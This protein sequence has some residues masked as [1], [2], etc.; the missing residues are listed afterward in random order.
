MTTSLIDLAVA[1]R[2]LAALTGEADPVVTWQTFDDDKVHKLDP[3]PMAGIQHGRLGD[4]D[5][6]LVEVNEVG[7]TLKDGR[8]H[9][10][11]VFIS[12]N[13]MNG[14]G[15]DKEDCVA[16]R[17]LFIDQDG[18]DPLPATWRLQPSIIVQRDETHWH[19][20]WLLQPGEE[21]ARFSAAQT[22][23]ACHFHSDLKIK[24]LP[25][26]LRVP[27]FQ[28]NK[29]EPKA[30]TLIHVEQPRTLY[31]IDEILTAHPVDFEQLD[32][33]YHRGAVL[34]GLAQ[35]RKAATPARPAPRPRASSEMSRQDEAFRKWASKKDT[36]GGGANDNGAG[37]DTAAFTIACEGYGRFQAGI[38]SSEA[39]IEDVVRDFVTRCGWINIDSE[40][41]RLCR[42]ARSAPRKHSAVAM[43]ER[44]V[45][46]STAGDTSRMERPPMAVEDLFAASG[47]KPPTPPAKPT[48]AAPE[49]ER[50]PWAHLDLAGLRLR[51]SLGT[52]GVSPVELTPDGTRVERQN[53]RVAGLPI[54]PER[55]GTDVASG[56]TWWK[57]G[58]LTPYGKPEYQWLS[59]FDLKQGHALVALPNGPVA[60]RHAENCAVYLTEARAS[61]RQERAEVTS[62][63]GWCGVNGGRRWVFPGVGV[64]QA[65]EYIGGALPAHGDLAKWKVGLKHLVDLP[66]DDGF[67]ALV[68][69][70][71]SA[72][73]PWSR[74]MGSRNPIIGLMGPSS[75]GKGSAL[76]YALS[77]WAD[78]DLMR[79]PASSTSKGIEDKAI[80][81][82]DLPIF[83]DELQQL[84][85]LHPQATGNVLYFLANGQRRTTSSK[86]QQAVGGERRYGVGFYAA[87]APILPGQNLG[88]L[89]RVI[90]LDGRPCPTEETAKILQAS[91]QH[92]GQL[93][94]PI[95]ELLGT[96]TAAEWVDQVRARAAEL[97]KNHPGVVG[98][99][100]EALTLVDLGAEVLTT[101][102][103]IEVPREALLTWLVAKIKAQRASVIDKETRC[104][105]QVMGS[106]VNQNWRGDDDPAAPAD[107][108]PRAR[109]S[110]SLQGRP[111]AWRTYEAKGLTKYLD[112]DPAHP[113]LAPLF[114]SHGGE[115]RVL[116][117]WADKGW[118]V[119]QDGRLR[120]ARAGAGRVVRFTND[121]WKELGR[122]VVEAEV[123]A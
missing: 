116:R 13:Q 87:E 106:V 51:W 109:T 80:A 74:L 19:A 45:Q 24:D 66:E 68:V 27:G 63:I 73:A 71:L 39:L 119:R 21:L 54:W 12:V 2:Y 90:E 123:T 47:G 110:V 10:A 113:Q 30:V 82:P 49:P 35:E 95:A 120:V 121:A 58:W 38:I 117:H 52:K 20:Y 102:T 76:D 60:K 28:H 72:A 1:H 97:R 29:S 44:P 64:H 48:A 59:E 17:A 43:S 65:V 26:V 100:P 16:L 5:R 77:L 6:H 91:T 122:T 62:R 11:G 3:D 75:S 37:N 108:V 85:E 25:R 31:S 33:K 7:R 40:V 67:T 8:L 55:A 105:H 70:C 96:H 78:V 79:L 15:R 84:G 99:D 41:E 83:M 111:M 69:V 101:T 4:L 88:V 56:S 36:R 94:G 93:A 115:D 22:H 118:I 23:L 98:D 92:T 42:G 104:L 61:V 14:R 32:E 89:F 103:G 112:I 18:G 53:K 86:T 57:L 107:H 81:L 114:A 9:R 46:R 34:V 50:E